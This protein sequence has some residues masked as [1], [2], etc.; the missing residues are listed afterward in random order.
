[1]G[2]VLGSL[3]SFS[4][5]GAGLGAGVGV[6]AGTGGGFGAGGGVGVGVG[7]GAG[8]G[9]GAGVG[10]G[11]GVGDGDGVGAGVGEA[12]RCVAVT[13]SP[14]TITAIGRSAPGFGWTMTRIDA[15]PRPAPG[16]RLAQDTSLRALHSQAGWVRT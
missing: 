5:A 10:V 12:E 13:R 9:V 8:L 14:A 11:V 16:V 6:G 2:M 4:G 1:M 3:N 15:S 7:V